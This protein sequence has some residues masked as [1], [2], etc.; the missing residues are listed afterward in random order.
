M[1]HRT[2][3]TERQRSALLDLPTDETAMLRHYTLAD[4]DLQI[5]Q[6]TSSVA[7]NRQRVYSIS[8]RH[9]AKT[10]YVTLV[11]LYWREMEHRQMAL[12]FLDAARALQRPC[13]GKTS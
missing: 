10:G 3:L 13:L 5:F 7:W 11:V 1:A 4:E 6:A 9:L 12:R 8:L 2:I